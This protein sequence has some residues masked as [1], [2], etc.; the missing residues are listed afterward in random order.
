MAA[1][2]SIAQRSTAEWCCNIMKELTAFPAAIITIGVSYQL[3][4]ET[5]FSGLLI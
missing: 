5:L 1:L 4:P 3:C 2:L